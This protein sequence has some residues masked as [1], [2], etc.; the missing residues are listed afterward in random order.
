[1]WDKLSMS[2]R[3][4]YI[5]LAVQNGITDVNS[6]RDTYNQYKSGGYI[7]W[8]DRINRHKGLDIDNDDSYDYE[9]FY[10]ENRGMARRMLK[11]DPEA[12]FPD[13]Y[14]TATHPT[15]SQESRY[16]GN[17]NRFNP[18]GITGGRWEGDDRYIMS[19]DQ[20]DRD[21]DTD[22]TLDYL[23]FADPRVTMYAPDGESKMLRSIEVTAPAPA[24]EYAL[25]GLFKRYDEEEKKFNFLK[26]Y[27]HI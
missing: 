11:D 17:V 15:F 23:E 25:G 27:L 22:R 7:K 14:K 20:L 2:E 5:Q 10:K 8:K 19:Q 12:H 4:K 1:M 13:T 21:W 3:A 18:E 26:N 16:S 24:V 9:S 6:I